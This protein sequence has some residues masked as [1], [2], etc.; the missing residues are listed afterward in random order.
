MIF[1]NDFLAFHFKLIYNYSGWFKN[2]GILDE[3]EAS[4]R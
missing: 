3:K 4:P 2:W 1:T